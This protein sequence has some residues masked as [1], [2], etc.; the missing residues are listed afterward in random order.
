M[1]K[2]D[3]TATNKRQGRETTVLTDPIHLRMSVS[4]GV[5]GHSVS[6]ASKFD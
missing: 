2:N 1:V 3:K 5:T 6:T 4:V